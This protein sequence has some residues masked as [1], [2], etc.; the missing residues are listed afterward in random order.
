MANTDI[1]QIHSLL[2]NTK[3]VILSNPNVTSIRNKS[4][5]LREIMKQ[6]VDV[7]AVAETKIQVS[8]PSALI[9]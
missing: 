4:D 5:N 8:F 3:N 2:N 9:K 6:N 1:S 7:L